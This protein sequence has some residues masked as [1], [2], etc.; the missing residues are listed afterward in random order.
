MHGCGAQDPLLPTRFNELVE[1]VRDL[2]CG[3]SD[4]R[5]ERGLDGDNGG[6]EQ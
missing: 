6:C 1:L 2:R 5:G 4:G 3:D